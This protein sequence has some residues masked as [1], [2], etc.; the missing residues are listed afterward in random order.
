MNKKDALSIEFIIIFIHNIIKGLSTIRENVLRNT[1]LNLVS[2]IL[3][4][5]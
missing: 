5:I 2:G 4:L 1:N 3:L